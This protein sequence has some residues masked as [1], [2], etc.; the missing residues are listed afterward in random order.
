MTASLSVVIP[1]FNREQTIRR[2]VL[3]VASQDYPIDEIIVVDDGSTDGTVAE[4]EAIADPRIRIARSAG[5][6]G[7]P[8]ARNL[9]LS[10]A[11][12]EWVAFQDSDD[13]WIVD[14][15]ARQFAAI[16]KTP[17]A[18]A[19]A[20]SLLQLYEGR[21][22]LVPDAIK[23]PRSADLATLL[24]GSFISTQTLVC[25]RERLKEID[26]FDPALPRFQDWDLVLRLLRHGVRF[27]FVPEPL[28]LAYD[29]PGNLTSFA[30]R[31]VDAREAVLRKHADLEQEFPSEFARHHFI[32]AS[33]CA[34]HGE[35]GRAK[36]MIDKA[37]K[38]DRGNLKYKALS[39]ALMAGI[40]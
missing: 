40:R 3:S 26:G 30:M 4:V 36:A 13:V 38:L 39:F 12:S 9:G 22:R 29:T 23:G 25:R 35:R 32:M 34:R 15:L 5:R 11:T 6:Q 16:A 7:A 10:L 37:L 24:A 14:K 27:A 18:E 17:G 28:A 20:C 19:V 31:G 33:T 1:A 8:A 2:A 21:A